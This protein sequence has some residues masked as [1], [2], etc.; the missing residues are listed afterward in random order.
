MPFEIVSKESGLIHADALIQYAGPFDQQDRKIEQSAGLTQRLK[1]TDA[2][3]LI[4][5]W[6][7]SDPC[8][9]GETL[10]QSYK[11]ALTEAAEENCASV[12]IPFPELELSSESQAVIL[13]RLIGTIN[14][15]LMNHEMSVTLA[16]D[17]R[18]T[19]ELSASL[20]TS[21]QSY[22]DERY[23]SDLSMFSTGQMFAKMKNFIAPLEEQEEEAV[24]DGWELNETILSDME[25]ETN[26]QD[27]QRIGETIKSRSLSQLLAQREASFSQ[28]LLRLI[29]EKG[30]TDPQV[31]KG[32][33]IDR[34]L[35]SKIRTEK[36]YRPSKTTALALAIALE[37]NLDEIKDLIG[38][39]GYALT[40]ASKLDIIVE[41]FV[42]QEI[43]DITQI[44][45]VL[46][47]LDQPLLGGRSF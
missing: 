41:Y 12:V 8:N 6:E 46:F 36:D 19:W 14:E 28:S 9:Q 21:I 44:N 33:N 2:P 13:R 3:L 27:F 23:I 5:V 11:Q 25:P 15:F 32:A 47:A 20:L 39:A 29:D 35:F 30:K 24:Q 42:V 45:E 40:H 26:E 34:R 31:Y 7:Q 18:Q 43:Y 10:A 17:R 38:R 16:V 22:I 1:Q 37:L 4:F